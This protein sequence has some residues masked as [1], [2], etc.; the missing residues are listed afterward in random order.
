MALTLA[1]LFLIFASALMVSSLGTPLVRRLALAVNIIDQPNARKVHTSPVPLLGG[2][3][4]YFGV[5]LTLLI[6]SDRFVV[7]ELAAIMGGATIV[8]LCGIVDDKWGLTA[9][10]KL[11]GQIIG[12]IVLIAGGVQVQLFA[13]PLYN[14][15][16][17]VVWVVG[18][19]NAINFLDNMDGL[20]GGITAVAAAFFLQL[21]VLQ[22]QVLVAALSAALLGACL[23]FLRHNFV[24]MTIFMG[25][26][27]SLFL[28]FILAVLGIKL[29]FLAISPVITWM[30]PIIV[31][32][33]PVFDTTLVVVSRLRRK[34]NPFNTA[35]KDHLSHR[36]VA[37]GASKHEAV[38]VCYMI[39]GGFGIIATM[40]TQAQVREAYA[41]AFLLFVCL[42]WAIWWL[43]THARYTPPSGK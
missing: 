16:L 43:E 35:G 1:Q 23:G 20:S 30:I 42:G 26:T 15:V 33:L 2:M 22:G 13:N 41:L 34:V 40:L 28:G 11:V 25:D 5:I 39:A 24:P 10:I 27:G 7:R 8:A 29:R 38:L 36:F 37:L 3:A 32:G 31:L 4:I 21:A 18:I 6:W 12:C 19:S 14:G 17:T 9:S